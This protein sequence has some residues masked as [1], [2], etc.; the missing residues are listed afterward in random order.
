MKG[1]IVTLVLILITSLQADNLY[2]TPS[3][4]GSRNG[5]DWAN[6]YAGFGSVR[7]GSATGQ[8]GAG[9]V[10]YVAGGSYSNPCEPTVNG[11]SDN[12]RIII[13]KATDADHGTNT[14]WNSSYAAQAKVLISLVRRAYVTVDG[15]YEYGFYWEPASTCGYCSGMYLKEAN[16]ITVQ[17]VH[18]DGTKDRDAWRGLSAINALDVKLRHIKISNPANDAFQIS[19]RDFLIEH[20]KVGPRGYSTS[21]AHSD[22]VETFNTQNVTFRYNVVD[23]NGI[24]YQFTDDINYQI[25]GNVFSGTRILHKNS[26]YNGANPCYF[27]NNVIYKIESLGSNPADIKNNVFYQVDNAATY[28]SLANN[29]VA[30]SNPFVDPAG[31]NFHLNSDSPVRD[32][33]VD[34]GAPYNFDPDGNERGAD[35]KWD[36][37]AYE[38]SQTGMSL[39]SFGYAQDDADLRFAID[40]TLPIQGGDAFNYYTISGQPVHRNNI[41]KTGIYLVRLNE[42]S[43]IKRVF[44]TK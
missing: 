8:V 1:S 24:M 23:W 11:T 35:G 5:S 33:G 28:L 17:Y 40:H 3:G 43:S 32:I 2:V 13:R 42:Y 10:L 16:H 7:W 18:V 39:P 44:I 27:Y 26:K 9:D 31:G 37:G 21:G 14:G 12:N 19:G 20:C 38:Y 36:M 22:M 4:S 29:Y 34:L 30:P 41:Q 6:A 25:Y 15:A